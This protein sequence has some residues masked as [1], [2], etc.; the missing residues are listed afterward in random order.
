MKRTVYFA[1]VIITGHYTKSVSFLKF[2]CRKHLTLIKNTRRSSV[3]LCF[4]FLNL[5]TCRAYVKMI[6]P[7]CAI[8]E[9][10][11]YHWIRGFGLNII[12]REV[13]QRLTLFYEQIN[14]PC[15]YCNII[16]GHTQYPKMTDHGLLKL[17]NL[18]VKLLSLWILLLIKESTAYSLNN[19]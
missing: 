15:V 9:S 10:P 1:L 11:V 13:E 17:A 2:E 6:H 19:V 16:I 8:A 4:Y 18:L 14:S 5:H 7:K 12:R 3:F